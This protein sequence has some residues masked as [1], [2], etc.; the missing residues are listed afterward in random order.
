MMSDLGPRL[1]ALLDAALP[2]WHDKLDASHI[3]LG[4]GI[5]WCGSTPARMVTRCVCGGPIVAFGVWRA[6][7]E[8]LD[9][10]IDLEPL[11]LMPAATPLPPEIEEECCR[12]RAE[13][14]RL[15]DRWICFGPSHEARRP[16]EKRDEPT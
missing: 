10:P 14:N 16:Q 3:C 9:E 7:E 1:R 4:C 12:L 8:K 15:V 5:M 6:W 11:G 13:H 2:G